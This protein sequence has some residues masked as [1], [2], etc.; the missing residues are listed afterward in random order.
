MASYLLIEIRISIFIIFIRPKRFTMQTSILIYLLSIVSWAKP[1]STP[2]SLPA[3]LV[4]DTTTA[5]SMDSLYLE[6][7]TEFEK[8]ELADYVKIVRY[9]D[10]MDETGVMSLLKNKQILAGEHNYNAERLLKL[11][12]AALNLDDQSKVARWIRRTNKFQSSTES[13]NRVK[14]DILNYLSAR[15]YRLPEWINF[16]DLSVIEDKKF[17]QSNPKITSFFK[18]INTR[19]SDDTP[20]CAA[21]VG[22]KLKEY[23][24]NF[25]LPVHPYRAASYGGF[26]NSL[27]NF[28]KIS[29]KSKSL[30]GRFEDLE[31]LD[32]LP[33]SGYHDFT[34]D[35]FQNKNVVPLGS[36]VIFKRK[37]G[38]HIGFAVGTIQD[39]YAVVENGISRTVNRKGV[40][41]L[42]GNQ[43]D[44]V[45]FMVFYDLD[46]VKAIS[47][48]T[49]FPKEEYVA[50]PELKNYHDLPEFYDKYKRD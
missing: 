20:W 28:A 47:M 23:D 39:S 41:V 6:L 37:G 22:S 25:K 45:Q 36:M 3:S 38:G 43:N 26:G 27:F 33:H 50:L 24:P 19:F 4:S 29:V 9:L 11:H 46:M 14:S 30:N 1:I 44:A 10:F 15:Q 12:N 2:Y 49:S 5:L 42:G 16:T 31:D 13:K 48:P 21:Y 35:D 7:N 17:G 40:V 32:F 18:K 34:F 8:E